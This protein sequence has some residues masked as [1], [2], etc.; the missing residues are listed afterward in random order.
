MEVLVFLSP[1]CRRCY[2]IRQVVKEAEKTLGGLVRFIYMDTSLPHVRK[3]IAPKY[4]VTR[5]PS[6]V[7]R[8]EVYFIGV[9]QVGDLVGM[10][11]YLYAHPEGGHGLAA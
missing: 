11:S 4:G 1:D 5:I 6:I 8:G 7:A 9:P 10:L 3:F 2:R